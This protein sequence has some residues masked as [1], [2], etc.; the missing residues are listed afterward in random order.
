MKIFVFKISVINFIIFSVCLCADSNDKISYYIQ[1]SHPNGKE[2][3]RAKQFHLKTENQAIGH[4]YI[5]INI[6]KEEEFDVLLNIIRNDG[7]NKTINNSSISNEGICLVKIKIED[8]TTFENIVQ[9]ELVTEC[10]EAIEFFAAIATRKCA[11]NLHSA[12]TLSGALLAI[13]KM[14]QKAISLCAVDP[15]NKWEH[16]R[17]IRNFILTIKENEEAY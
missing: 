3:N 1:P 7:L 17:P 5:S 11:A 12:A 16:L 9:K 2:K 8:D 14:R 13:D 6:L 10:N 4:S 15:D